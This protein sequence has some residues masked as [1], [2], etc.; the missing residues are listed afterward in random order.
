M[1]LG[2]KKI[3]TRSWA[4]KYRGPLYI[5]AAKKIIS[6]PSIAIQAVFNDIAFQPSDLPLGAIIAKVDLVDVK[7]VLNHNR[8]DYPE[9]AFG[10]YTPYR[11]MWIT[12]NLE[13]FDPIP[14]RGKQRIFNI[15]EDYETD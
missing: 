6:W 8:P 4:T 10:D 7:K 1:A 9:L 12:D 11:F 3:E 2:Y 5:H 13:T 15:K 14:Y